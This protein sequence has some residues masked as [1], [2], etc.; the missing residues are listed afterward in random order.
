MPLMARERHYDGR[1][2]AWEARRSCMGTVWEGPA[3]VYEMQKEGRK[4]VDTQAD[5]L[6]SVAQLLGR[7]TTTVTRS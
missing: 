1:Y 5:K 4:A 3:S 2:A 6:H 7:L